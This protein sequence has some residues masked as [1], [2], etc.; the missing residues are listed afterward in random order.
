MPTRTVFVSSTLRDLKEYR[1]A[2][3]AAIDS[4]DG[5][6]CVCME[7]FGARDEK[8]ES[9]IVQKVYECNLFVGIVGHLHGSSP[10]G[11]EQSYTELEYQVAVDANKPRLMFCAPED[12]R[13]S[14]I[15]RAHV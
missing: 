15:G 14:E 3:I 12:F 13:V 2:V 5:Y 9:F 11:C 1:A 6:E 7:R 4:L 10:D 8:S